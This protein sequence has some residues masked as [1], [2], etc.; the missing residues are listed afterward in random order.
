MLGGREGSRE[1]GTWHVGPEHRATAVEPLSTVAI[2]EQAVVADA[3]ET[4]RDDVEQE[5]TEKIRG[6]EA[7]FF[8]AAPRRV[9]LVSEADL[10]ALDA[11]EAVIRDRDPMR[12]AGK[13]V[14]DLFRPGKRRLRIDVPRL[15]A[16]RGD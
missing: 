5:A 10:I 15:R 4:A 1:R 14:E 6:V 12:V 9:V 3:H 11:D 13:I 2:G 8:G 7:H 16:Q